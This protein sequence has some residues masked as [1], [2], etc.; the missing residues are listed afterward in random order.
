M[1][2]KVV[3]LNLFLFCIFIIIFTNRL[4]NIRSDLDILAI[5]IWIFVPLVYLLLLPII[6]IRI[7]KT[8]SKH[9][10]II[11]LLSTI[12][13]FSY[14]FID[15]FNS[16]KITNSWMKWSQINLY[17]DKIYLNIAEEIYSINLENNE[18]KIYTGNYDNII[19]N[20]SQVL[21]L[22]KWFNNEVINKF[23]LQFDKFW[24]NYYNNEDLLYFVYP[25]LI[26]RQYFIWPIIYQENNKKLFSL[27]VLNM[28]TLEIQNLKSFNEKTQIVGWY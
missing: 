13:F 14:Y 2:S 7:A 15:Y 21:E 3:K 6:N 8:N 25:T 26:N 24:V 10:T 19:F 17:L 12:L 9:F 5:Y 23:V 28:K 1:N 11:V 16:F 27:Y 22:N 18:M 20:K 4:L